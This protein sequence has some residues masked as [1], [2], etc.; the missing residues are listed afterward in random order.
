MLCWSDILRS[1]SLPVKIRWYKETAE[2]GVRLFLTAL[3][4]NSAKRKE[5]NSETRFNFQEFVLL[6][7]SHLLLCCTAGGGWAILRS[8]AGPDRAGTELT[9]EQQPACF[10][11]SES[12]SCRIPPDNLKTLTTPTKVRAFSPSLLSPIFCCIFQIFLFLE[13]IFSRELFFRSQTASSMSEAHF[14][15]FEHYNFDQDKAMRSGHSGK[16]KYLESFHSFWT[17]NIRVVADKFQTKR[18]NWYKRV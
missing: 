13:A 18:T 14:D 3:Q 9:A 11:Q 17:T 12:C 5:V 10:H 6:T 16:W 7:F 1:F 2:I 15:E 8:N 4:P